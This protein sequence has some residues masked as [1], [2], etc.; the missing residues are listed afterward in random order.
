VLYFGGF[1]GLVFLI[2]AIAVPTSKARSDDYEGPVVFSPELPAHMVQVNKDELG[3]TLLAYYTTYG[4][5]WDAALQEGSPQQLSL[6]WVAGSRN[7]I[8]LTRAQRVQRYTLGVFYYSTFAQPN[9]YYNKDNDA[10]NTPGWTSSVNWISG[11]TE[12]DW[13]GI[14][15]SED[16]SSVV[17]I[18]LREHSLTGTLPL[19][20]AFLQ[21]LTTLDITTN[22]VYIEGDA[23]VT[24]FSHLGNMQTLLVEDN[25][26]VSVNGIPPSIGAMTQ[27]Q[28]ISMSYNILQGTIDGSIFSNLSKLTHLEVES[29][30]LEGDIPS[31]ISQ[32]PDLAYIYLRRNLL[33][34]NL[35]TLLSYG[36]LPSIFAL[37]LDG[38]TVQGS[39]PTSIGENH[40]DLA[41]LSI[42]NTTLGGPIP[43]EMGLLSNLQRLWLYENALTGQV[44][45]EIGALSKLEVFEVYDNN[46]VG[47]MPSQ[48]C[49]RIQTATYE[50]KALTADCQEVS[51]SNCCTECF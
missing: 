4:L 1:L 7:Y 24:P 35:P 48:L 40:P 30:Y 46:L 28:K 29:N 38:N 14:S 45:T 47:Q 26:V 9:K 2:T 10:S 31:Q 33:T 51:C 27:L 3:N 36:N 13:E 25:Y 23:S 32:L 50:F 22:F 5:S 49:S 18:L 41:S 17:G 12:C 15:C 8:D 34:I 6:A 20:L 16:A 21:S 11:V 42:T 19:E 39:I 37:W 43:T 44:P